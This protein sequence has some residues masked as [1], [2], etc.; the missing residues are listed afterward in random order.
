MPADAGSKKVAGDNPSLAARV[1]SAA[2][3][4]SPTWMP[5]SLACP[6]G[7]A[8]SEADRAASRAA[9]VA[10][11]VTNVRNT[12]YAAATAAASADAPSGALT[13]PR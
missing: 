9:T 7:M 11:A 4:S 2:A 12:R 13:V 8:A 3:A 5:S 10:G 1:N 6:S